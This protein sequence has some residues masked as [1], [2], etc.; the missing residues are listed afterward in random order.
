MI[1]YVQR[2]MNPAWYHGRG[3]KPPFFEGW[4]YKLVNQDESQ[5]WAI[6]PGVFVNEESTKSHA[7]VQVL[8]GNTGASYYHRFGTF[9]AEENAFDITIGRTNHFTLEQFSLD[10]ADEHGAISGELRFEGLQPWPISILSPGVMGW[11]AWLPTMQT[12]HGVLSFDHHIDGQLNLYGET[13]DF[14]GGRGYIEKDWGQSFPEGYIWMQSNHFETAGTSLT[15][16]I[17]RVPNTSDTRGFIVGLWHDGDLYSFTTYNNTEIEKLII[18]EHTV[19]W[20]MYRND[21][22]L[23]ITAQRASGGLL[24]GPEVDGMNMR[25]AET[26]QATIDYQLYEIFGPRKTL[27]AQGTGRNAGLEVVGDIELLLTL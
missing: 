8:N 12:Y 13:V 22:E 4:Y 24:K 5:R 2:V 17:A 10:F 16:S 11:Y 21:A 7:F 3:A 6:I 14:T 20:I 9:K 23:H 1:N 18:D 15:A 27:I 25:V 19:E 26:M